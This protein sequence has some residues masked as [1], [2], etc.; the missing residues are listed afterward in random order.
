MLLTLIVLMSVPYPKEM[1]MR[2]EKEKVQTA[3]ATAP[4]TRPAAWMGKEK[5][6]QE[7]GVLGAAQAS[8]PKTVSQW[9]KPNQMPTTQPTQPD[10]PSWWQSLVKATEKWNTLGSTGLGGGNASVPNFNT[11]ANIAKGQASP[12]PAWAQNMTSN[13]P[14]WARP[15]QAQA[16]TPSQSAPWSMPSFFS[17]LTQPISGPD[18]PVSRWNPKGYQPGEEP[19]SMNAPTT[20][21]PSLAVDETGN[22]TDGMSLR[23]YSYRYRRAL[24]PPPVTPITTNGGSGSGSGGYSRRGGGGGGGYGGFGTNYGWDNNNDY[25]PYQQ[26]AWTPDMG[27][28]QWNWKG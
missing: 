19:I 28:F 18:Q 12:R 14:A 7:G 26:S 17:N 23:D 22:P 13:L 15:G 21:N 3:K 2:A 25:T 24:P 6:G 1:N 16:G 9:D 4:T 20:S 11:P 5:G 10:K 8:T 27:L